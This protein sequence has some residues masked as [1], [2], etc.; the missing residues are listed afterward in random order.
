MRGREEKESGEECIMW[1]FKVCTPHQ[2]Y[3]AEQHGGACGMFGGKEK[4]NHVLQ[5]RYNSPNLIWLR[6]RV[7]DVACVEEKWSA[8][9]VLVGIYEGRR[10]LG[11]PWHRWVDDMKMDLKKMGEEVVDWINLA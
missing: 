5:D 2:C 3:L 10:P 8:F 1:S 6:S 4:Y 9:T 7:V 11:R